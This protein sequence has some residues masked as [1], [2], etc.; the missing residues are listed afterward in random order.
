V[1]DV[2]KNGDRSFSWHKK[3]TLTITL[4]E[5]KSPQ[6]VVFRD[7]QSNSLRAWV[8]P[9]NYFRNGTA[10]D[11]SSKREQPPFAHLQ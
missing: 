2:M 9:I 10:L 8:S 1:D 6:H 5:K 3:I 4:I 11:P 7:C